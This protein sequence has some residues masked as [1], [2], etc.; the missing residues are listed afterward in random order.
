MLAFS[1]VVTGTGPPRLP[2]LRLDAGAYQTLTRRTDCDWLQRWGQGG[3]PPSLIAHDQ[4]ATALKQ[5]QPRTLKPAETDAQLLDR[6]SAGQI[7]VEWIVPPAQCL[8]VG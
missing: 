1:F 4:A 5:I 8:T 3:E 7:P 6:Q 2:V